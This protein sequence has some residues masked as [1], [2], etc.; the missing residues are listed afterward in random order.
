MATDGA[1]ANDGLLTNGSWR[2]LARRI[3]EEKDPHKVIGLA[4][5]LIARFNRENPQ[6][7]PPAQTPS[8]QI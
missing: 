6:T 1:L 3:Q 5:Q 4:Q 2:E 8:Q 7:I